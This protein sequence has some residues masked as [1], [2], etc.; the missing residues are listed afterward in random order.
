M[1][2]TYFYGEMPLDITFFFAALF[3]LVVQAR[4]VSI[5]GVSYYTVLEIIDLRCLCLLLYCADRS[6]KHDQ[7]G[8]IGT[9][10]EMQNILSTM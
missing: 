2:T 7:R 4:V 10:P 1:F 6:S 5:P 3:P 9:E 8:V